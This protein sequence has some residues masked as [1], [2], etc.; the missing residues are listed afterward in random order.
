MVL[1]TGDCDMANNTQN[2]FSNLSNCFFILFA[3]LMLN[4]CEQQTS[5]TSSPVATHPE[6][7][8]KMDTE[9]ATSYSKGGEAERLFIKPAPIIERHRTESILERFAPKSPAIIYDVGGGAGVYAF[10]LAQ[11]GYTVHLI[12]I[13][14]LH[15]EQA[16]KRMQETGIQLA[17]NSV[18]DARALNAKDAVADIVLLFGPLYHL[19][20]KKD[21]EKALSEAYRILKPGGMLFAAAISR[22]AAVFG[23]GRKNR[24]RDPY[25]AAIAEK[26]FKTGKY[27]NPKTSLFTSGYFHQPDEFKNEIQRAGFK[28]VRLMS[29]EGPSNLFV[30][31]QETI[32][33]KKSLEKLLYFLELT[34]SDPSILGAS[35]HI[36]AIGNK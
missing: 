3:L 11:Q 19:Q 27:N 22:A 28:D 36:M 7:C 31:M 10:P 32:N 12:D 6:E 15:I 9:I 21:R 4:S 13:T 35:P 30:S 2:F 23:F 8:L 17:E 33:D 1:K 34:E 25:F 5:K 16:H 26:S 29:I 20:E 14:P 18:G 24:L